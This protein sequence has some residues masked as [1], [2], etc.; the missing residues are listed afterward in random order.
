MSSTLSHDGD[1]F[2]N[3]AKRPRVAEFYAG[4]N[5]LITGITGF[6]GKVLLE[7]L[8]R[9][10][11]N[12]GTIYLIVRSKRGQR[13]EDRI[14]DILKMQVFQ[15]LRQER[16]ESFQKI[17]VLDGDLTL[18]DLGL[19]PQDRALLIS[20]VNVVIHSAATV[21]FDEPIKNAVR[22]N[23][24][25]T[26]KIIN[27]CNEME[28]LKV[29]VHVSTCYCNCDRYDIKEEIYPPNHDPDHIIKM[30]DWLDNETLEAC[31]PKLLGQ[32]PNTYTF[33][34]GLAETLVQRES[35]GYPVAIVRPSIVVCSWKEPFPGWVDNFN[36]PTGLIVAVATGVLKSVYSIPEYETDFVPVDVVVNCI[37]ASAWNVAITRPKDVQV[38][39]CA[40]GTRAPRL[41][42]Q[43]LKAIQKSLM[44]E[45][46]FK[47]AIRYPDIQL[48]NNMVT[49]RASMFLQ[50]YIP[51]CV[52]D[53]LLICIGK[54]QWLVKTYYKLE[55]LLEALS[56]FTTHEWK[57]D[58]QHMMSMYDELSPEDKKEFNFDVQ[59]LEW[60]PFFLNYA[61]GARDILLKEDHTKVKSRNF[62]R[63]YYIKQLGNVLFA[64]AAWKILNI[65]STLWRLWE[66]ALDTVG[67]TTYSG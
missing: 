33:T 28:D 50:H 63:L 41:R 58:T 51:A 66:V 59:S 31:Q 9:S 3:D 54:K 53:A 12:V 42:W 14:N 11:P 8:L 57:F 52:G 44:N 29:L 45:L 61:V 35:R 46:S 5:V 62:Q 34:K 49:H 67:P 7:K 26:R 56:Y 43:D 55:L 48:R 18:P 17:V 20:K 22:M 27:L 38:Y 32:M 65:G 10:C 36:G 15:R 19:K 6:L 16:P 60:K 30:V 47:S 40:S 64:F 1:L 23:L 13:A 25:G 4:K 21:K 2:V 39:Q 24:N 37:L